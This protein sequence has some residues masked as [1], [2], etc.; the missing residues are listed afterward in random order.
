MHVNEYEIQDRRITKL[1]IFLGHVK[2]MILSK[3]GVRNLKIP[4]WTVLTAPRPQLTLGFHV[5][6]MFSSQLHSSRGAGGSGFRFHLLL[7]EGR[8]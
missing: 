5:E 1:M 6:Y 3:K 8:Y 7:N 4:S 2:T